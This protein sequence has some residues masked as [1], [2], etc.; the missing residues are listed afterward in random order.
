MIRRVLIL[1]FLAAVVT[2]SV[3]TVSPQMDGERCAMS[4]C[5]IPQKPNRDVAPARVR[6]LVDCNQ[7]ASTTPSPTTAVTSATQKK[8]N[9]SGCLVGTPETL[10]YIQHIR[11][12]KSPTRSIAGCSSRYLQTGALLI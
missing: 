3:G 2:N 10:S 8:T 4:C 5:R 7:P 1:T 11:F 6:C 9:T 12:P